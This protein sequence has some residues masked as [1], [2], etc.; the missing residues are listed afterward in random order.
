MLG[1]IQSMFNALIH[2]TVPKV[3]TIIISNLQTF[4]N[5]DGGIKQSQLTQL[6]DVFKSRHSGS[7]VH[8]FNYKVTL[9]LKCSCVCVWERKGPIYTH[10]FIKG[11]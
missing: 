6:R 8:S 7:K 9:S 10:F 1:T 5:W 4:K 11:I 3:S 2:L